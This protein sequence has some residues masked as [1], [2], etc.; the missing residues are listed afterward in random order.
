MIRQRLDACWIVRQLLRI[1]AQTEDD[2]CAGFGDFDEA[3]KALLRRVVRRD[4]ANAQDRTHGVVGQVELSAQGALIQFS[5]DVLCLGD[6]QHAFGQIQPDQRA[7]T[8]LG[9]RFGLQSTA[10][11]CVENGRSLQRD[12]PRKGTGGQSRKAIAHGAE[13]LLVL[14]RPVVVGRLLLSL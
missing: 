13:I 2:G 1:V 10:A 9:Q 11:A 12:K 4:G 6:R 5:V 3:V 7:I 14:G 8:Q